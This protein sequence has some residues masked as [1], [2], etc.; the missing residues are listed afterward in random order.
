MFTSA[1]NPVAVNPAL[2]NVVVNATNRYSVS[3]EVAEAIDKILAKALK[4]GKAVFQTAVVKPEVAEAVK[5]EATSSKTT[6]AKA[7]TKSK[8]KKGSTSS[9]IGKVDKYGNVWI[10]EY[11]EKQYQAMKAKMMKAGTYDSSNRSA[12]YKA[13][14]WIK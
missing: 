7:S 8:Q 9:N 4:D 6:K 5:A 13:L 1:L 11:D 14:G 2:D 10:A 12:V 3:D